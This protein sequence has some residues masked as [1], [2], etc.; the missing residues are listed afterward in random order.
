MSLFT[1]S[2]L[3]IVLLGSASAPAFAQNVVTSSDG[4]ID[5]PPSPASAPAEPTP[6]STATSSSD[7]A[8]E[9]P[10]S[11]SAAES[12]PVSETKAPAPTSASADSTADDQKP[13]STGEV[14]IKP[15]VV[16]YGNGTIASPDAN[17]DDVAASGGFGLGYVSLPFQ[18]YLSVHKGTA[19]DVGATLNTDGT[20][21][22][23]S[24]SEYGYTILDP[25]SA[26]T[27]YML[28]AFAYPDSWKLA[29][30]QALRLD[31]RVGVGGY[32]MAS[33]VTWVYPSTTEGELSK[34]NV[35]SFAIAPCVGIIGR[36]QAGDNIATL[37]SNF[38]VSYRAIG[39][40]IANT[41]SKDLRIQLLGTDKKHYVG[42]EVDFGA[43]FGNLGIAIRVSYFYGKGD[44][45]GLSGLRFVPTITGVIPVGF[46]LS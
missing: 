25:S 5:P 31:P 37:Y 1:R 14:L 39:G 34:R 10:S 38:C 44:A 21:K 43:Q 35:T 12:I 2:I 26:N 42:P 18:V 41:A 6:A 4:K 40:D 29:K 15:K 3:V 9:T 46:P 20:V 45:D 8:S 30:L 13:K 11:D 23:G 7:T 28:R 19:N 24:A 32:M 36:G 33:N 27:S 17:P 16:L 22:P